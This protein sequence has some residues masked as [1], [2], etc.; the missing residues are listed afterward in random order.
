V[1][2]RRV[3]GTTFCSKALAIPLVR[4]AA[5]VLVCGSLLRPELYR[6]DRDHLYGRP[7]KHAFWMLS[8]EA[9]HAWPFVVR[10]RGLTVR[11]HWSWVCW[12]LDGGLPPRLGYLTD[13]RS[14]CS[15]CPVDHWLLPAGACTEPKKPM[16]SLPLHHG[17]AAATCTR[18]PMLIRKM[19][20]A[21]SFSGEC[22]CGRGQSK[23][24][25]GGEV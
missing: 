25:E 8:T 16:L 10:E 21:G 19:Q 12:G 4:R 13:V 1:G 3:E 22:A 15:P 2:P 20:P 23:K 17:R 14:L 18:R 6:D 5:E 24:F 7:T 9:R 11:T